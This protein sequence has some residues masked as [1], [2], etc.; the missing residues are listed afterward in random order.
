V[1]ELTLDKY[2]DLP[3]EQCALDVLKK[4]CL[5][6]RRCAI[7]GRCLDGTDW[8]YEPDEDGE[9]QPIGNVFST[10]NLEVDVMVV[11]Q[12]PGADEVAQGEPFVG[13]SGK[14][15]NEALE[16]IVGIT[17]KDLYITNVVKCYT[18]AN[19]KPTQAE[20]DNCRDFLDL[21]VKLVKPKVIVA[22]GSLAFKATTGM[23]GIM[24][25]CSEMVV[26]PRYL[27]PVIAMLHPS[28]YNTNNPERREMFDAAMAELANVLKE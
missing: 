1:Q 23:S 18:Q 10:M 12:N 21:E 15:F 26:S 3:Y 24:K 17:R 20:V 9:I 28:P 6:C 19:R 4:D 7:G 11:G 27:I 5:A 22:L 8:S 2:I 14:V 16:K 13:P 25:H